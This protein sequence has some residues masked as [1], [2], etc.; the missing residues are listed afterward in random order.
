MNPN[1][2]PHEAQTDIYHHLYTELNK[3]NINGR[4]KNQ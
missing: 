4:E 1:I 3:D 2:R